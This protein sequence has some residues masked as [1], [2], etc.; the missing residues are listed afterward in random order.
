MHLYWVISN[1]CMTCWKIPDIKFYPWIDCT[2]L[3]KPTNVKNLT[4]ALTIVFA[5]IF[6][7]RIAS[8]K[9]VEAQIIMYKNYWE[10]NLVFGNGPTQSIIT[11]LKGSSNAGIGCK[12]A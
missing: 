8:G 5:L 9:R 11:L 4:R 2:D 3:G 7:K 10:P 12:W 1:S 6:L